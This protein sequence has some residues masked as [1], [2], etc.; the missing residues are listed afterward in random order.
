MNGALFL[1]MFGA[2]SLITGLVTE[3]EKKL[4]K[5]FSANLLALITGAVVAIAVTVATFI[6]KDIPY[7]TINV[8]YVV[9]LVFASG[10]G[11]ML[12]YD[13]VMQT[14]KQILRGDDKE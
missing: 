5:D 6:F 4:V 7:N 14:I 10:L 2:C 1:V 11:A 9:I 8:T 3:A 13:K 12:G